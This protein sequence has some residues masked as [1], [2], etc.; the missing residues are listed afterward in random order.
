MRGKAASGF[1]IAARALLVLA[2][3]CVGGPVSSAADQCELPNS[4]GGWVMPNNRTGEFRITLDPP[5][6]GNAD[7]IRRHYVFSSVWGNALQ[8]EVRDRSSDGCELWVDPHIF[9][10]LR[11]FLIGYHA[12]R[13]Q[14]DYFTAVCV[15]LFEEIVHHWT[16][17]EAAVTKAVGD[18]RRGGKYIFPKGSALSARGYVDEF[19]HTLLRPALARIYDVT[20]VMHALVSVD[21]ESYGIVA[22]ASLREW[23]GQQ[24]SRQLGIAPLSICP[25][26]IPRT[27]TGLPQSLY[28]KRIPVF[29]PAAIRP[30][31]AITI[32]YGEAGKDLRSAFQHVVL[33]GDDR[34][35]V[36]TVAGLYSMSPY[37]RAID[38]KYCGKRHVIDLGGPTAISATIKCQFTTILEYDDW[39]LLFCQDCDS[40]RA[41]EA[42][43]RL[44]IDDPEL[45]AAQRAETNMTSKGPYLI[46]VA[47]RPQ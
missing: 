16:P 26:A 35:P 47:A 23:L 37:A 36:A 10:D 14:T 15:P 24:R 41:A 46:S 17:D 45:R 25:T 40:A 27:S 3:A 29:P 21:A 42:V 13:G 32:P 6:Y 34:P 12:A 4:A 18:L 38:E 5:D 22:A 1:G 33:I 7:A 30:A 19:S 43:A 11:A 8:S 28:K 20:S 44:V 39:M 2:V 31:G 9:P